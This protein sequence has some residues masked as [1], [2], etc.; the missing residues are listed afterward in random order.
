MKC[1]KILLADGLRKPQPYPGDM[2]RIFNIR[3]D[4]KDWCSSPHRIAQFRLKK[5]ISASAGTVVQSEGER[6]VA[7]WLTTRGLVYRYA[8]KFRI[9]GEFQIRPDFHIEYWGLDNPQYKMNIYKKQTP[10]PAGG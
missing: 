1:A 2:A 7:D 10:L 3:S 6:K 9:I 8:A 5:I 4:A